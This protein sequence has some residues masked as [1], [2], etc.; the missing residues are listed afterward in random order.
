MFVNGHLDFK[1]SFS[2][3]IKNETENMYLDSYL[4]FKML[5]AF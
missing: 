1:Y 4:K 2:V 5:S 3:F